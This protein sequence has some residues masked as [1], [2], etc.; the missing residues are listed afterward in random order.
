MIKPYLNLITSEHKARP[1]FRAWLTVVLE[2]L[3]LNLQIEDHFDLSKAVGNQLDMLGA[4]IGRSRELPFQPS[5]GVSPV[6]DDETYRL[7]LYSKIIQN[8]WDGTTP[9]MYDAWE[10]VFPDI[11]L[12][13]LDNQ[14]MSMSV[15][16]SGDVPEFV[17]TIF[18]TAFGT[19]KPAGVGMNV[20]IAKSHHEDLARYT[21]AELS[22]YTHQVIREEGLE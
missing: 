19:P 20:W 1:K 4:V 21:H 18:M 5:N 7:L 2:V 8:Q 22:A 6:L 13:I 14:D 17:K 3:D 15:V 9:G 11:R 12:L 10:R 16:I